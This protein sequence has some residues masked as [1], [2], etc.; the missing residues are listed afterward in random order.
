MKFCMSSC[1]EAGIPGYL[2]FVMDFISFVLL[3]IVSL[4]SKII[5]IFCKIISLLF[6]GIRLEWRI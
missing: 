6:D 5:L 1:C 4:F 2:D 3:V